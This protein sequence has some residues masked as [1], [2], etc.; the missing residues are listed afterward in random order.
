MILR[1]IGRII[2]VPIAFILSAI[3]GAIILFMLVSERITQ[4]V[5]PNDMLSPEAIDSYL[6]LLKAGEHLSSAL[7]IVPAVALV[8]IGEVASIR[9]A[10]YYVLGGG[11]ALAAIPLL[12]RISEVGSSILMPSEAVWHIFATAGFAAGLMYWLLAGRRA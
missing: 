1:T 8:I 7:T 3:V 6:E 2:W 12:A 4:T 10:I 9:S 11:A 5:V